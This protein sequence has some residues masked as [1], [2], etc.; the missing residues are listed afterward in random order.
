MQSAADLIVNRQ[1]ST[2]VVGLCMF[3]WSKCSEVERNPGRVS[4]VWVFRGTRL[5]VSALFE[6]LESGASPAQFVEWFSGA[7]LE[8]V[9][10]VLKFVAQES[11]SLAL[12]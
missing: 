2:L 1:S 4:G 5:P 7:S 6:N 10:A 8:Q 9:N 11:S 12:H 3:D